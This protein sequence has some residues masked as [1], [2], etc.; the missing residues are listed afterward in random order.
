MIVDKMAA[1]HLI[2]PLSEELVLCTCVSPHLKVAK[3]LAAV[4]QSMKTTIQFALEAC[5]QTRLEDSK[6]L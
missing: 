2:G 6:F 4:E 5:L 3:W 1:A